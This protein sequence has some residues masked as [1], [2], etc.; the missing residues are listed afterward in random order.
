MLVRNGFTVFIHGDGL[1]KR[2]SVNDQFHRNF[3]R[4]F[5]SIYP[6]AADG[7]RNET[8]CCQEVNRE[9][10]PP[11]DQG[12]R[13]GLRQPGLPVRW[14]HEVPPHAQR[15]GW[16]RPPAAE[17]ESLE[18][19]AELRTSCFFGG[20]GLCIVIAS[21]YSDYTWIQLLRVFSDYTGSNLS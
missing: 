5:S 1:Q 18:L 2:L 12:M 8:S 19:R 17:G 10:L 6:C 11:A 16:T 21:A 20:G 9:V 15:G 7:P 4:T 14:P 13:H 3:D